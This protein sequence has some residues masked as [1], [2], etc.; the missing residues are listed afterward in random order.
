[1][2]VWVAPAP[3]AERILRP[4]SGRERIAGR[5]TTALLAISLALAAV[6]ALG[7]VAGYRGEVILTGS[8]RP[9]LDPGDLVVMRNTPAAELRPGQIVSF[10]NRSGATITHRVRTVAAQRSGRLTVTTQGDA[11]N[12][13]E[14][15]DTTA[16]ATVGRL[17][18]TLPQVG[19]V[20]R[21]TGSSTGRL[22]VLGAIGLLIAGYALR[23]I[24]SG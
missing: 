18:A 4:A 12:A 5:A 13:P 19:Q 8:M 15:W 14:R 11:N 1:M 17:V 21:W 24:W 2:G 20:T 10:R 9:A 6:V 23:R 22:L 3:D 16:G 7:A